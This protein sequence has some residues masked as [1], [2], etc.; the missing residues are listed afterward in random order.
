GALER[1]PDE[2]FV[3]QPLLDGDL[4]ALA[5]VM[6]GGE[7]LVPVQQVA[8]SLFP[9]PCGGSALARTTEVAQPLLEQITALL[10]ETGWEGVVQVQWI[11]RDDEPP[12]LIDVNPRIYGSLALAN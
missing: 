5:G 3:V 7:L 8:L 9:W 2:A 6:W 4:Y 12:A 11:G 10:R 1:S